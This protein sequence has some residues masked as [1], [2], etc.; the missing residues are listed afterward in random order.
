MFFDLE[1]LNFCTQ[2]YVTKMFHFEESFQKEKKSQ[3]IFNKLML[4]V[5]FL[6]KALFLVFE[7][8]KLCKM[9]LL[10]HKLIYRFILNYVF[11]GVVTC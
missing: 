7:S 3:L 9:H 6:I 11:R 8:L 1:D 4:L 2:F 5:F 10:K